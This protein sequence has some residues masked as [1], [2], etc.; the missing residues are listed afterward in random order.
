MIEPSELTAIL[1]ELR[2]FRNLYKKIAEHSIPVE[3]PLPGDFEAIDADDEYYTLSEVENL[4]K[5][6]KE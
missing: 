3:D 1:D 4:L 5:S 2:M 6:R